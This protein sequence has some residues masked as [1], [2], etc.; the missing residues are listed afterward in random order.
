MKKYVLD[1]TGNVPIE[2]NDVIQWGLMF[3]NQDRKVDATT[4]GDSSVSTVF[5]GLDHNWGEGE[6]V[7]WETLVFDG[8]FDG[9]MDRC[10]GTREDAQ[11]MHNNMVEKI[12]LGKRSIKI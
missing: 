12:I 1:S 9:L 11:Q 7:L 8:P 5:L 3:S 2:C 4:I 6:P 10:S